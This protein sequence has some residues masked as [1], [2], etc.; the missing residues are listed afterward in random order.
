LIFSSS[1]RSHAQTD[2][3]K[4]DAAKEDT[5]LDLL[6]D[7]ERISRDFNNLREHPSNMGWN[8]IADAEHCS[9]YIAGMKDMLTMWNAVNSV[10]HQETNSIMCVPHEATIIELLRVVVKFLNDHPTELHDQAGFA[11][12]EAWRNAYPC[13]N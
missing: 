1:A 4:P 8:E 13:K 6:H 11:V 12:I 3:A 7:C 10:K 2:A 9:G 5:G